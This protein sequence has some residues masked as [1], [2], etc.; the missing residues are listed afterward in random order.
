MLELGDNSPHWH[1][2]LAGV[3]AAQKID[4]VFCAGPLMQNLWDAL[5][6]AAKGGYAANAATLAPMLPPAL[7]DGDAVMVKGSK[8]SKA[9]TLAASLLALPH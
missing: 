6:D 9:S 4:L 8:G 3:I 7:R 5:P 2:E 1:A